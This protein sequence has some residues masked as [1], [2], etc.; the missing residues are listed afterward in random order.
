MS[1]SAGKR[2]SLIAEFRASV[3]GVVKDV[4]GRLSSLVDEGA[5][6]AFKLHKEKGV[7]KET[8]VRCAVR[9]IVQRAIDMKVKERLKR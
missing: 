3:E 4:I 1:L 7:D 6:L 8:A 2:R 5:R 9:V